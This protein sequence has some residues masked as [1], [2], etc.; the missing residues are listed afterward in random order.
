MAV[1]ASAGTVLP[2]CSCFYLFQLVSTHVLRWHRHVFDESQLG[3][4][5][6]ETQASLPP[7][8]GIFTADLV[9]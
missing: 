8:K 5:L 6:A 7:R 3:T 9:L 1:I 2:F 4:H